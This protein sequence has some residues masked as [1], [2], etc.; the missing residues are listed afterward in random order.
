[1]TPD[2]LAK[3]IRA[4]MRDQDSKTINELSEDVNRE[5]FVVAAMVRQMPDLHLHEVSQTVVKR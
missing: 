2:Q 5:P 4:H 3:L 1:M